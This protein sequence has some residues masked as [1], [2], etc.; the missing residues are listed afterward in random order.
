ML[1]ESL[2]FVAS[3]GLLIYFVSPS[4]EPPEAEPVAEEVQ[5][6]VAPPVQASDDG[7]GYDDEAA[8]VGEDGF[9][10]GDPMTL[11]DDGNDQASSDEQERSNRL[12][13]SDFDRSRNRD[14]AGRGTSSSANSPRSGELGSIDN[15][16]V[17][18]TNNANDR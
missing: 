2:L 6:K 17:L 11:L 9:T 10:F 3:A 16:I 4:N 12:V 18:P 1:K 8:D 15:P 14:S 5:L 7:W 13:Q